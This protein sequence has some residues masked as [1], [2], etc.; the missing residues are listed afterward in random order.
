MYVFPGNRFQS[1]LT[2]VS[3]VNSPALGRLRLDRK[4]TIA[5][6]D[7]PSLEKEKSYSVA[8]EVNLTSKCFNLS[9][10]FA[11]TVRVAQLWHLFG[12]VLVLRAN[13]RL[14]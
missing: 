7:E 11:S 5:Y 14:G 10:I 8:P 6:F 13:F 12:R 3:E 9:K 4:K 1:S 2:C